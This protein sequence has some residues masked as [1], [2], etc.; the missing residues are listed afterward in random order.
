MLRLVFKMKVFQ[1]ATAI[2][3]FVIEKYFGLFA[4]GFLRLS[5]SKVCPDDSLPP[6][7]ERVS[8]SNKIDLFY[9]QTHSTLVR[10]NT[11]HI[12]IIIHKDGVNLIY[13]YQSWIQVS[14]W[15]SVHRTPRIHCTDSKTYGRSQLRRIQAAYKYIASESNGHCK[16]E[17]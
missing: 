4:L 11:F 12:L 17:Y 6:N 3:L 10:N 1:K 5:P 14:L 13:L 16:L 7:V 9:T 2:D 8:P 15:S